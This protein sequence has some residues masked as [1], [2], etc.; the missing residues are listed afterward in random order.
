MTEQMVVDIMIT[1]ALVGMGIMMLSLIIWI[2]V[3]VY[4][5]YKEFI[6]Y[7]GTND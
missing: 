7:G 5:Y 2:W 1:M 3:L 6:K 4:N